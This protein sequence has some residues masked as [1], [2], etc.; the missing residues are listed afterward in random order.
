MISPIKTVMIKAVKLSTNTQYISNIF[1]PYATISKIAVDYINAKRSDNYK[2][3]YITID[4]W[5]DTEKA[6]EFMQLVR[7]G[8]ARL[9][10]WWEIQ[11]Y[12]DPQMQMQTN[13]TRVNT[14]DKAT[15]DKATQEDEWKE[16]ST[17]I[18]N[19]YQ[20]YYYDYENRNNENEWNEL[21]SA[22]DN[23]CLNY[24]ENENIMNDTYKKMYSYAYPF[25]EDNEQ[26]TFDWS[27]FTKAIEQLRYIPYE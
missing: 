24:N 9:N 5:N 1:K 18:D 21:S 23:E 8:R 3:V 22:I 25:E 26:L 20:D 15:Q 10:I 6:Y 16:L 4:Q 14:Q 11:E 7:K 17:A 12:K 19:E 2:S 27:E 13:W